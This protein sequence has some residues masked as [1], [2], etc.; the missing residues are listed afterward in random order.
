MIKLKTTTVLFVVV[1]FFNLV[2]CKS[3]EQVAQVCQPVMQGLDQCVDSRGSA[4]SCS[5]AAEKIN[6]SLRQTLISDYNR[7]QWVSNCKSICA[8]T[9]EYRPIVRRNYEEICLNSEQFNI[10]DDRFIKLSA[11]T[12][13][14]L[15]GLVVL[16][17]GLR[18]I[19]RVRRFRKECIK[20]KGTVV[21]HESSYNYGSKGTSGST[22][23]APIIEFKDWMGRTHKFTARVAGHTMGKP[24]EKLNSKINVIYPKDKPDEARYDSFF[25]LWLLPFFLIIWGGGFALMSGIGLFG[26]QEWRQHHGYLQQHAPA[27]ASTADSFARIIRESMPVL[28][29]V[30]NYRIIE[31]QHDYIVI[32]ADYRL[33]P[34]RGDNI[35]MGAITLTDGHSGGEWGYRP[36]RLQKGFG[37]AQVR[38]SASSTYCSN[39]IRLSIYQSGNGG[40]Y[41]RTVPYEKCWVKE[42]K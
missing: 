6:Q 9:F 38:L 18:S 36:A 40:I 33:S 29:A 3:D 25:S 19:Q 16:Y 8:N 28:T 23:Y 5:I 31:E 41:E 7:K 34:F 35:Y 17:F 10:K 2:G 32:E 26:V 39:Q 12:G 11:L 37:T 15:V 21:A 22:V 27:I 24:S 13:I 4:A 42:S 1:F 30:R 20:T 14:W